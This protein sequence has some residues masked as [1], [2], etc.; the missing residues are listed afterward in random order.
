MHHY[1]IKLII[2]F[3]C[4]DD[5]QTERWHFDI[6][7]LIF[8]FFFLTRSKQKEKQTVWLYNTEQL[9]CLCSV[10][11]L[12]NTWQMWPCHQSAK[13][14][15]THE[16]LIWDWVVIYSQLTYSLNFA[17]KKKIAIVCP[18]SQKST[19]KE[20]KGCWFNNIQH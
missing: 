11:I 5:E 18:L 17:K 14:R 7:A 1:Y 8:F 6:L 9:L 12:K 10:K 15:S 2:A 19:S 13:A 3:I 20:I 4:R 16:M